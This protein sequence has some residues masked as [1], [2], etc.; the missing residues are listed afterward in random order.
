M[1]LKSKNQESIEEDPKYQ[2]HINEKV[3]ITDIVEQKYISPCSNAC[4]AGIN[5][6]GF[7]AL[8]SVG[9][10]KDAY[11]VIRRNNPFPYTCGL[12]C[13][14]P[15]EDQCRRAELE[16]EKAVNI[17][18]LKSVAAD[19]VKKSSESIVEKKLP[20]NGKS[21]GIIGGGFSGLTCA[22]F[23]TKLGYDTTVYEAQ[24]VAGGMASIGIPEYRA[25]MEIIQWEIQVIADLGV[26]ILT[27]TE[28]GKD[29]SFKEIENEHDAV[30][31]STGMPKG[32]YIGLEGEHAKEV[33]QAVDFLRDLKLNLYF[34]EDPPP[35]GKKVVVIGG[36]NV[37]VDAARSVKRLGSEV[38]MVCLEQRHEMPAWEHEV[39]SCEDEDVEINNGWGPQKII[40]DTDNHAKGIIFKQCTEVF[41]ENHRFR[42]QYCEDETIEYDADSI[43]MAIGQSADSSY[44]PK[45]FLKDPEKEKSEGIELFRGKWVVANDI[46]FKTG[47]KGIFAGGD[48]V[49]P[50]VLVDAVGKGRKAAQ[51]IDQYLGG[52]GELFIEDGI[53]IP[54]PPLDY[55]TWRY[56]RCDMESID[57]EK[58]MTTFV[59]ES[60]LLNREAALSESKRCIG[61]DIMQFDSEKCI[62]CGTCLK[63]CPNKAISFDITIKKYVFGERKIRKAVVDPRLC[64]CCGICLSECPVNAISTVNWC[65]DIYFSVIEEF[66]HRK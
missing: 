20:S 52:T 54:I 34:E 55:A 45:E 31:I 51:S 10:E 60:C 29:I 14:H 21:V 23:L 17:C 4:P 35:L 37:A 56:Q 63:N 13:P 26:K 43:I 7:L 19:F 32:T 11:H 58:R 38:I 15:C 65:D 5:I 53:D 33:Y 25:P 6:P 57:I 49:K 44:I 27:N 50:G 41:D 40:V 28:V 24:P 30:Y 12:V 3:E 47:K 36:G 39:N 59:E 2:K 22:Y 66:A 16:N 64:E 18:N 61:C 42:P 46:T 8:I 1:T 62:G 9:R 48:I